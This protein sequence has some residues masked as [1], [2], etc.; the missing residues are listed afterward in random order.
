[1]SLCLQWGNCATLKVVHIMLYAYEVWV[2]QVNDQGSCL[3]SIKNSPAASC[4][5][6]ADVLA[7]Q[8]KTSSQQRWTDQIELLAY[9]LWIMERLLYDVNCDIHKA[10]HI[11][12]H[13]Q[14]LVYTICMCVQPLNDAPMSKYAKPARFSA[15][16]LRSIQC[17]S[18]SSLKLSNPCNNS[19][20][21]IYDHAWMLDC[22]TYLSQ[23]EKFTVRQWTRLLI[24]CTLI[25]AGL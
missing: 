13:V 14:T 12:M 17:H 11:N 3:Q 8:S 7:S 10:W 22:G 1:M 21:Q 2:T 23:Y 5:S 25:C 16:I 6:W 9:Q 18:H 20:P 24:M 19:R 4:D 15:L